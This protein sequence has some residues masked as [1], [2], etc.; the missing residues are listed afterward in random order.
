MNTPELKSLVTVEG[1]TDGVTFVPIEALAF[2]QVDFL[3]AAADHPI[4]FTTR[5][6]DLSSYTHLRI[7]YDGT[8]YTIDRYL[9]IL[10]TWI[11]FVSLTPST[12]YSPILEF[13]DGFT[14]DGNT[15]TANTATGVAGGQTIYGDTDANGDLVIE[16]T[17]SATK[18]TSAVILQ[19]GGGNVSVGPAAPL[20][21]LQAAKDVS[22]DATTGIYAQIEAT[23]AGANS[24]K[25]TALGYNTSGNYGFIQALWNANAFTDLCLQPSGGKAG[26]GTI[27]PPSILSVAAPAGYGQFNMA[28][29]YTPTS[30]ADANG[31]NGDLAYDS[32]YV[33]L[34]V[35]GS[36]KRS[37]LSTF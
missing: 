36:W 37:A 17:A 34:K 21:T 35:G 11:V 12:I 18:T 2:A 27:T 7:T 23:G 6:A 29:T 15:I 33:Y 3:Y 5:Y 24:G 26:V 9:P 31:S 8:V 14:R 20:A 1:S 28:T 22:V 30:S 4:V 10:R 19:P 25:R 32:N 16:G 13:L